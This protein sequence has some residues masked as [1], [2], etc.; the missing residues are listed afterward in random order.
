MREFMT[1][2]TPAV[3]VERTMPCPEH[4]SVHLNDTV[5]TVIAEGEVCFYDI[6]LPEGTK[7]GDTVALALNFELM[8]G[9][10][11]RLVITD[12][13]LKGAWHGFVESGDQGSQVRSK[14]I[15]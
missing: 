10:S 2:L 8:G 6:P 15:K 9:K 1:V 14:G 3:D 13:K 7:V 11:G 12:V 4:W 5:A